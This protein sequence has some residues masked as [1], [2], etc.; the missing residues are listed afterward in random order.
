MGDLEER[1]HWDEYQRAYEEAISATSKSYAPWFIIPADDKWYTRL[2]IA[3]VIYQQFETLHI[4]YPAPGSVLTEQLEKAKSMLMGEPGV[5]AKS[6]KKAKSPG[7]GKSGSPE[8][9]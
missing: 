2:A 1:T 8:V 4:D 9:R 5:K 3:S 6:G 7:V